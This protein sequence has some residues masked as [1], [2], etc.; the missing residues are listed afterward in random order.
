MPS[1]C[2]NEQDMAIFNIQTYNNVHQVLISLDS[3]SVYLEPKTMHYSIGSIEIGSAFPTIKDN[4]YS[5]FIGERHYKPTFKGSGTIYLKPS[6]KSFHLINL[7]NDLLILEKNVFVAATTDLT[8]MPLLTCSPI[9]HLSGTPF[10]QTL[11]KG[12]GKLIISAPGPM[13]VVTISSKKFIANGNI[14]ARSTDIA[15]TK[16]NIANKQMRMYKGHGKIYFSPYSNKDHFI[17]NL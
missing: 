4:I 14:L 5:H 17:S 13:E 11:I 1:L 3:S 6:F 10:S 16:I 9:K 7:N 2:Y 8:I 12:S 15:A